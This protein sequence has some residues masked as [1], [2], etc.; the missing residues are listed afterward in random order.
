MKLYMAQKVF[1][2]NEKFKI[3]DEN[4]QER[5]YVQGEI[6]SLGAKF[7]V[8]DMRDNEVAYVRQ[9]LMNFMPKFEVYVGDELVAT[10][11][12]NFTFFS[13]SYD[14]LGTDWTVEGDFMAHD[15]TLLSGGSTIA[16]VRKA[17]FT[18]GDSYEIDIA[19]GFGEVMVI[20]VVLGIDSVL[21][22]SQN[23]H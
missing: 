15:Y 12:K 3:V 16:T 5:Y 18:W 8:M 10:I 7:H 2:F 11:K 22:A 21:D 20:A 17:W 4:Q 23:R 9:R 19:D 13:Q 6:L 1:S 14:I